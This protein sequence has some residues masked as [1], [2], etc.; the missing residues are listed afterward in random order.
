MLNSGQWFPTIYQ[1]VLTGYPPLT[2]FWVA[3]KT[4]TGKFP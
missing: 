2:F 1:P 3:G 4:K